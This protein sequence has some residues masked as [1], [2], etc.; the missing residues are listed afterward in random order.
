LIGELG[1]LSIAEFRRLAKSPE[2]AVKKIS[3]KIEI[4]GQESFEK[5]L[6]GIRAYQ[7]SPLQAAYVALVAES[8]RRAK[9]VAELS[10]EKRAAGGDTL[11]PDE[12]ASIVSFNSTLHF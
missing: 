11:S 4:L 8:F 2:E 7:A 3:Q 1:S 5:R 9:P 10:E 12:I 6:E